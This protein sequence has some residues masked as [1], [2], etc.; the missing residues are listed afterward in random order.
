MTGKIIVLIAILA[1]AAVLCLGLYTLWVGGETARTWSNKLMRRQDQVVTSVEEGKARYNLDQAKLTIGSGGLTGKGLFNGPQTRNGFVPEQR[2]DFIFTAVGTELGFIGAMG[3]LALIM[4]FV[5][6]GFTIGARANDGF[7]KLLATGLTAMLG[8]Q[9]FIIV[10]GV[11]RLV[12]LTGVTLPFLSYG[13]SSVVTNFG[14]VAI[15]LVISHR[16]DRPYRP[17]VKRRDRGADE[18]PAWDDEP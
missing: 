7:S 9:A 12:P 13:G 1:V 16:T 15:L 5:A 8:L 6:R 2:T 18:A 17:R 10:G 11:V 14:I 4:L 3:V